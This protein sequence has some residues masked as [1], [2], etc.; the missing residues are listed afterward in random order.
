MSSDKLGDQ[1]EE[2]NAAHR[3]E[4]EKMVMREGSAIAGV[5]LGVSRTEHV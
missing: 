3:G 4:G 5:L 1:G 2:M